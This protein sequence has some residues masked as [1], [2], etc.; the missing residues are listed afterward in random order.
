MGM[1][2]GMEMVMERELGRGL[3]LGWGWCFVEDHLVDAGCWW[4]YCCKCGM[5][6]RSQISVNSP[7]N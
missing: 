3:G 5:V 6:A 4:G 7:R 2:I 1:G